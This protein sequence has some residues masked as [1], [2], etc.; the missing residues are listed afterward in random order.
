MIYTEPSCIL[1][2]GALSRHVPAFRA[3]RTRNHGTWLSQSSCPTGLSHTPIKARRPADHPADRP[4]DRPD[5]VPAVTY[6]RVISAEVFKMGR[7]ERLRRILVLEGRH[8]S[9]R[10]ECPLADSTSAIKIV[11]EV[12]ALNSTLMPPCPVCLEGPPR[13]CAPDDV[14]LFC[15]L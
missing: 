14:Q 13:R 6:V 5:D 3:G 8:G 15:S 1:F 11:V 2:Y 10:P 7:G 4:A 12:K 9:L